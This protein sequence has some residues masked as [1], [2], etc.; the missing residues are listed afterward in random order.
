MRRTI[1]RGVP[2]VVIAG[3]VASVGL[4]G[5]ATSGATK[6]HESAAHRFRMSTTK[7]CSPYPS[8][9]GQGVNSRAVY[10]GVPFRRCPARVKLV[11]PKTYGTWRCPQ[12]TFKVV[13]TA[14]TG[15][16][17]N[18]RGT[19]RITRGSGTGKLRGIRGSGTFTGR[20][21]TGIYTLKGTVR[22]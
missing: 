11:I 1:Q 6:A 14:S 3:A 21:S 12:G 5:S 4:V 20:I 16:A 2:V 22:Y 17:E 15:A 13:S 7:F 18:V 10:K 8:C 19:W 9:A